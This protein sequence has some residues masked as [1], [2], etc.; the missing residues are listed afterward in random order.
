MFQADAYD[1]VRQTLAFSEF[2]SVPLPIWPIIDD[3]AEEP[4]MPE[5]PLVTTC[6]NEQ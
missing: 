1:I 2:E 3:H 5:D 4:F 6:R